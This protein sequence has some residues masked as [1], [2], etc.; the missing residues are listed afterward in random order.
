[1]NSR[2]SDSPVRLNALYVAVPRADVDSLNA[3][4]ARLKKARGEDLLRAAVSTEKLS[5]RVVILRQ[6]VEANPASTPALL[7]LGKAYR[8]LAQYDEAIEVFVRLARLDPNN[9]EAHRELG[10][11]YSKSG[12]AQLAASSLREAVRLEP[13][14]SEAWSNL[15]GAL[16]RVGMCRAPDR[17]AKNSL[18]ESRQSYSKAHELNNF[19]VYSGLNVA[20]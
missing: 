16:R 20:R 18:I 1:L 3:E 6:A 8:D 13:N 2:K 5:D 9:A 19:D 11:A 17:Y 15:G 7:E 12:N 14:D 10:V 4:I